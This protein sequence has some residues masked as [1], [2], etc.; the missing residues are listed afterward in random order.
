MCRVT[1]RDCFTSNQGNT[2]MKQLAL[3]FLLAIG[4]AS[5]AL[6]CN[7]AGQGCGPGPGDGG[8]GGII[9][10]RAPTIAAAP[11]PIA[12]AGILYLVAAAG[13]A[14]AVRRWRS[15]SKNKL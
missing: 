9:P 5:S 10:G 14:Y 8:G 2:S 13:G 3:A 11:A 6:A 7:S 1:A 15:T 4:V 12:G